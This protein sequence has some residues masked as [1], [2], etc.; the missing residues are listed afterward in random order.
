[1]HNE[2]VSIDISPISSVTFPSF[3]HLPSLLAGEK[4][5]KKKM[6]KK[7]SENEFSEGS[8]G[9]YINNREETKAIR[10]R[11]R[12]RVSSPSSFLVTHVV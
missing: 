2:S 11:F 6:R 10:I 3:L 7:E 5:K 12:Q 4:S 9:S 1:M 8:A